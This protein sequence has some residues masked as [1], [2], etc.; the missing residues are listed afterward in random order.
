MFEDIKKSHHFAA[1]DS[2]YLEDRKKFAEDINLPDLY[3]IVDQNGLY[4]G[5]QTIAKQLAIY[6]I[7]N[8]TADVPGD[9]FEFGCWYGANLMFMAKVFKLLR[10]QSF[11]RIFGFD[12]FEGL[13]TF[14][15]VDDQDVP[16]MRGAYCGDEAVLRK[17][18]KLFGMAEQVHL[19]KGN[20]IE[21]IPQFEKEF[22]YA[23]VSFA[24]IDFDL[25]EPCRVALTFLANRLS[26]GGIV[27]FD[28]ALL[29]FWPG[30]GIAMREFVEENTHSK[31][32]FH[33]S[34]YARQPT[35]WLKKC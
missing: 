11:K 24:Y 25:Y 19:V 18:I 7:I 16:S 32:T 34:S 15:P 27:A 23:T 9:I 1:A 6:E 28:E 13:Q 22:P 3:S 8:E 31:F 21:T 17:A 12:G 10:P 14:D 35:M 2:I 33:A 29:D 4:A 20:A 26:P 30:E 5:S